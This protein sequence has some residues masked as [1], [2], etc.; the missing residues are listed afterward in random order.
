MNVGCLKSVCLCM[1]SVSDCEIRKSGHTSTSMIYFFK[2][3]SSKKIVCLFGVIILMPNK[4]VANQKNLPGG[5]HSWINISPAS[6]SI[7][8]NWAAYI[9]P[10]LV[11]RQ[12]SCPLLIQMWNTWTFWLGPCISQHWGHHKPYLNAA[13]NVQR[14]SIMDHCYLQT[15]IL[16]LPFVRTTAFCSSQIFH[17]FPHQSTAPAAIILDTSP[18]VFVPRWVAWPCFH[19]RDTA[20]WPQFFSE[21]HFWL[22]FFRK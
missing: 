20:F 22:Y 11:C 14:T 21:D 9:G 16:V 19:V 18:Y 17:I 4:F 7:C 1:Q 5:M 6:I 3:D 2:R 15:L 12:E 13:T 10:T 8:K